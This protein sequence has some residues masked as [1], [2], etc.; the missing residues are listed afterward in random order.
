MTG[1]GY[2][3]AKAKVIAALQN[4]TYSH[5]VPRSSI[6]TKNLLFTGAVSSEEV[7]DLIKHSTGSHHHASAHHLDASILVHVIRCEGWYVKFYFLD[8]ATIFISVHK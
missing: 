2:K 1:H 8:P 4:G 6:E 7:C 5:A 3:L